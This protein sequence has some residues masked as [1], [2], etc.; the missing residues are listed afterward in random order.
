MPGCWL[1]SPVPT[2]ARPAAAGPALLGMSVFFPSRW[3]KQGR[4]RMKG[5]ACESLDTLVWC[6]SKPHGETRSQ[7]TGTTV[8]L[9]GGVAQSHVKYLKLSKGG[10]LR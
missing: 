2:G 1:V 10:G 4:I 7:N 9:V 8:S 3:Q 6:I 5:K